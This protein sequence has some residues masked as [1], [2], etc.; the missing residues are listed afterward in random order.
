MTAT[1][2]LHEVLAPG[3]DTIGFIQRPELDWVGTAA[4]E[5]GDLLLAL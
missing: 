4:L 5:L 2:L 1:R 3:L